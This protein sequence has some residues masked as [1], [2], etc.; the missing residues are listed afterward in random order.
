MKLIRLLLDWIKYF[1]YESQ[2]LFFFSLRMIGSLFG[3]PIYPAE[4]FEQMYLIGIGSLFLIVL[5]GLSAGQGMALQFSNELADFGSKNYLGRI[6][7]IAIV[8]E[9]GP[10]LTGV[11]IAARVAAGI[12]AEIG[13]MKSSNQLD[14]MIAFG[15]DPIRKLAAPRL[16][17]LIIM[18]PVLTIV[19]D[20]ISIFG[21]W[22]IAI[23]I[24]H[25]TSITYWTAVKERL[26]FGN[27]FVGILKPFIYA[28]IIG[29]ISCYKGFTAEGG[30]KGVG[31]A[32]TES[33]VIS[34]ITILVANFIITKVVY[35]FLR[36][37]L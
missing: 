30:T 31:R 25:I 4:T 20:V 21:G 15:I 6:M 10:V 27:I 8:R 13:A 22:I 2:R 32:T 7:A 26:I 12:T 19:C 9:L 28:F 29:F 18:V 33:V 11:M 34:S 1:A 14:A 5:T 37:Y 17:S 35:S 23:F 3:R 36:G 16:I 24:S